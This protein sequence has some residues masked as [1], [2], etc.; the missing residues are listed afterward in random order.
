MC[1]VFLKSS[2]AVSNQLPLHQIISKK[3]QTPPSAPHPHKTTAMKSFPVGSS[4]NVLCWSLA[5]QK[6]I[7][8]GLST[9]EFKFFMAL[10]TSSIPK[11]MAACPAVLESLVHTHV[12]LPTATKFTLSTASSKREVLYRSMQ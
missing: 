5:L 1:N 7:N 10:E 4:W 2:R 12:Q 11:T 3:R 9:Q 6:T 8:I